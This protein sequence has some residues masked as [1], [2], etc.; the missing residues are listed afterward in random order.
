MRAE[1]GELVPALQLTGALR[2]PRQLLLLGPLA[3][4][5]VDRF[6]PKATLA[7]AK[8]LG[9]V[10][11]LLLLLADDFP[12]LA[13]LS[14]LHGI[15]FS[16]S[17]PAI[18]ALPPRLVSDEHLARTNALVSLTDEIAIVLGPVIGAG[19]IALTGF[20]GA[21]VVDAITY[22]IGLA[23]PLSVYVDCFGKCLGRK[24]KC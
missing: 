16:I 15:A 11:A 2:G 8:V 21:F 7:A 1:A 18:Q 10:A 14:A 13:L 19:A 6:G 20:K 9:V 17:L 3:G 23:D 4:Q 22:A 12:T 24:D 5:A